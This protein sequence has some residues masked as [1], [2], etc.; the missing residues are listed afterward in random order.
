MVTRVRTT[1]I[2]S[3]TYFPLKLFMQKWIMLASTIETSKNFFWDEEVL[4]MRVQW[5][6]NESKNRNWKCKNMIALIIV[7]S[8]LIIRCVFLSS[9]NKM[10]ILSCM[11]VSLKRFL[12]TFHI[13]I[14]HIWKSLPLST[15]YQSI[16]NVNFNEQ[17]I[18]CNIEME[19][20]KKFLKKTI[21]FQLDRV[22]TCGFTFE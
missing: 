7:V 10:H 14:I 17:A 9:I 11:I 5:I 18:F 12:S 2:A 13:D 21:I 22:H 16:K 19:T 1:T 4:K 6:S 8:K 15:I 20:S 3:C